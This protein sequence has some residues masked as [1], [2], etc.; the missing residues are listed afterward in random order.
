MV[1]Q[2]C[3]LDLTKHFIFLLLH[4]IPKGL[5]SIFLKKMTKQLSASVKDTLHFRPKHLYMKKT[6]LGIYDKCCGQPL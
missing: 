6:K 5:W 2:I 4:F 1:R 3:K